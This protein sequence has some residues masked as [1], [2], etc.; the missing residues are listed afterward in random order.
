MEISGPEVKN[1]MLAGSNP[2]FTAWKSQVPE[3]K[4]ETGDAGCPADFH[5]HE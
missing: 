1:W 3:V 4:M 5:T 2:V